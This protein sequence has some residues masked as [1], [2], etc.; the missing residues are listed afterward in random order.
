MAQVLEQRFGG[1]AT[2]ALVCQGGSRSVSASRRN[3][4]LGIQV[5]PAISLI[6]PV[7]PRGAT[8]NAP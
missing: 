1:R 5:V 3:L 6:G 7:L 4:T 8:G 2:W